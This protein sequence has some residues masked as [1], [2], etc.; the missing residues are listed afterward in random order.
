MAQKDTVCAHPE[1]DVFDYLRNEVAD[2]LVDRLRD[3]RGR[4]F[5]VALDLGCHAG[6]VQHSLC[7]DE[8]DDGVL[9]GVK[10]LWNVDSSAGMLDRCAK[11]SQ[12]G[13]G[14]ASS[15][16]CKYIHTDEEALM[17]ADGV[18]PGHFDVVFS[19]LALHWVNDLPGVLTQVRKVLRPDGAFFGAMLGGETLH[20]LRA[21][22]ILAD[23]ERRG[24]VSRHMSPLADGRDAA[25]LLQRAGFALPA[26]DR[27]NITVEYSSAFELMEHVQM[28]AENNAL[29]LGSGNT[30]APTLTRDVLAATAAIYQE[31]YGDP[32]TGAVPATFQVLYLTGWA[33]APHQPKAAARGSGTA[34]LGDLSATL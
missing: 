27:D 9:G 32:E 31:L 29:L 11:V 5:P 7:S 8:L 33:P 6:H 10:E 18:L 14:K 30:T 22:F 15:I 1:A 4:D 21:C 34:K 13:G 20:E 25:G 12:R 16:A 23:Q 24:G 2:R 3:I 28:M 17:M 19:S 26:V